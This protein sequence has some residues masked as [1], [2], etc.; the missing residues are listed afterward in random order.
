MSHTLWVTLYI[1]TNIH[2]WFWLYKITGC[3]DM[4]NVIWCNLSKEALVHML[5]IFTP[6]WELWYTHL[7]TDDIYWSHLCFCSENNTL[8]VVCFYSRQIFKNHPFWSCTPLE[9]LT[10]HIYSGVL[11][12]PRG[13]GG[14]AKYASTPP[15][16]TNCITLH[17]L[18]AKVFKVVIPMKYRY[19]QRVLYNG[20]GTRSAT[21]S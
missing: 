2:N 18:Y 5:I 7:I 4:F 11:L 12:N 17:W 8:T 15:P 14:G 20:W 19:N 21:Y 1:W 13:R 3:Y 10:L 6:K 16:L 9:N